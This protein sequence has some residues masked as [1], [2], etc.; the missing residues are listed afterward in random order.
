ME[1]DRSLVERCQRGDKSAFDDLYLRHYARLCRFCFRKLGDQVEAEDTAQEAFARAWRAMPRFGG[2]RRFYPWL[3][4][5]ASNLCVDLI[6][7][8]AR[9]TPVDDE[10]LDLAARPVDGGQ[11]A[12]VEA[13]EDREMLAV[14]MGRISPRYREV[15][16]L[17]EGYEWSYQQIAQHKGVQM[18]TIE[19]LLYRARRSLRREF[20]LLADGRLGVATVLAVVGK[21][22]W[23]RGSGLAPGGAMRTAT[24]APAGTPM[25]ALSAPTTAAVT[26]AGVG[27]VP[28][29]AGVLAT[30]LAAAAFVVA[31]SLL[32]HSPG[33]GT[34]TVAGYG[35]KV[36]SHA[37]FPPVNRA[38]TTA[39]ARGRIGPVELSTT[40]PRSS[41]VEPA[42]APPGQ[43]FTRV[44]IA[45]SAVVAGL[46][47]MGDLTRPA[48]LGQIV[49][50]RSTLTKTIPSAIKKVTSFIKKKATVLREPVAAD[51]P[52]QVP[53][54]S[55]SLPTGSTPT[56]PPSLGS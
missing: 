2:E 28:A 51:P 25:T 42:V 38:A 45:D 18:S 29:V 3:S 56:L 20:L 6:R 39:L 11:E 53:P 49:T 50:I 5:I 24:A 7:R 46:H 48:L 41:S 19:T 22:L 21:M 44:T 9:S 47:Q 40:H 35:T 14:A 27:L 4:V 55:V 34:A 36:V 17:R 26:G 54:P 33:G 8:K 30:A 15:L 1:R 13:Q 37:G 12:L 52:V 10:V 32:S 31:A 16:E 43:L 23:R